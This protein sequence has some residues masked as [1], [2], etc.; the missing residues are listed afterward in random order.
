MNPVRHQVYFLQTNSPLVK[1]AIAEAHRRVGCGLGINAY[2][3]NMLVLGV[4]A[5][6]LPKLIQN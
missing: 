3:Q 2:L 1:M 5:P 6:N 4:S